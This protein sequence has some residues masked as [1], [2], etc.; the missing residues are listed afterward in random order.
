MQ[1]VKFYLILGLLLEYF[2]KGWPFI[3][4]FDI[5]NAQK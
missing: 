2:F 5:I 3:F 4:L 1:T